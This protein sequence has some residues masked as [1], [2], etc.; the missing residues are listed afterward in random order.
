MASHIEEQEELENFKYFW[1]SWGRWIFAVLLI[2]ALAY[3]GWK[4]Y[5]GH[6]ESRQQDAAAVLEQLVQKA[7]GGK[8]VSALNGDLKNLQ[9]NYPDSTAAAQASMMV[10]AAEFDRKQ[11]A[12]ASAHLKWVLDH[13]QEPFIRALA[14]SRLAVVHLQQN[15]YTEALN[16][17]NTPVDSAFEP[18]ILETKGDVF[19]AQ[20]KNTEAVAAY[21][22]ALGKL[23]KDSPDGELLKLKAEQLK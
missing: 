2:S 6:I 4:V 12:T 23:P 19:A 15:Q 21:E 22:Q 17:L 18:M 3:F 1:K 8:D 5:Q 7:Q 20:G 10:A 14:I 13:Q 11:Y 16:V 9:E